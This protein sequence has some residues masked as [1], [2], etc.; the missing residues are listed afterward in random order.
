MRGKRLD[1][2]YYIISKQIED[3]YKLKAKNIDY[4]WKTV[5]NIKIK[6]CEEKEKVQGI[7]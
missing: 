3:T 5:Y 2:K 1:V 4:F 7:C 6:Y